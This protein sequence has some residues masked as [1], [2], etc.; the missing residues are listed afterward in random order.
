MIAE[1]L[2]VVIGTIL[3]YFLLESGWSCLLLEQEMFRINLQQNSYFRIIE[4]IEIS[5]LPS[6]ILI[7][8]T[9]F[10]LNLVIYVGF[11]RFLIPTQYRYYPLASE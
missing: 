1:F 10:L 7:P 3:I 11:C 5:L 9:T 8:L 6:L 4:Q 2:L